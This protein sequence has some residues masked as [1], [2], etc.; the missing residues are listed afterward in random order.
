MNKKR[1][2]VVDLNPQRDAYRS[3][4]SV[5]RIVAVT[6]EG[7]VFVESPSDGIGRRQARFIDGMFSAIAAD[8]VTGAPVLLLFENNDP[9]LP[10]I[11]GLVREVV[12]STEKQ[13][14]D[15]K[16]PKDA[17]IDGKRIVFDASEEIVLRCGKS[18][19]TL[20]KDGKVV[21]KGTQI[22]S[23]STGRHKIKGASVSIN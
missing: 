19:V 23:R 18:A 11:V 22:T 5:G 3:N 4:V 21:V 10:I 1:A 6:E 20:R 9:A 15:V 16:R 17:L 2:N 12:A 13:T 14:L 7:H 8:I